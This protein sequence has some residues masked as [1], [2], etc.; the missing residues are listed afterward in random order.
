MLKKNIYLI[1]IPFL[2]FSVGFAESQQ[3]V[4]SSHSPISRTDTKDLA[5]HNQRGTYDSPVVVDIKPNRNADILA[6][7]EFERETEKSWLDKLSAWSTVALA[8]ITLVLAI[9]TGAL[10]IA[11]KTM[12]NRAD[13]SA[14]QQA[15]EIQQS[16]A[17]AAR[18]AQA[19]EDVAG[20]TKNNAVLMQNILHKQMRAYIAVDIGRT[21]Y[22][23]N[24]VRFE[25]GPVITNT[26][27][28]PA[29]NVNFKVTAAILDTDLPQDF[30][31]PD[32]G[33][34]QKNDA[35]LS[36]RQQFVI[37]GI[38]KDRI[39]EEEADEAMKGETKRLYVWGKVTYEDI[40][41]GV[42]ET[43]FCHNFVFQPDEKTGFKPLGFY[44]K[45]H[46]SAT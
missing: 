41:D 34:Q 24:R 29:R 31:F 36:P 13:S 2:I 44:N 45:T 21:M 4:P 28:T 18:S 26:G 23:D 8:G 7:R 5:A 14:K 46:N 27:F 10:W 22:Q 12:V 25:S 9:F 20:A 39:S 32:D 33:N 15:A 37:Y 30:K 6:A 40:F 35:A 16:I 42:W 43:N 38:V 1:V 11:T 17:Q 19:M 3:L